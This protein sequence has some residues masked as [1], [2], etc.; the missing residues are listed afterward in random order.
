MKI[1][2]GNSASL[3][4]LK[5]VFWTRIAPRSLA[6]GRGQ[7]DRYALFEKSEEQKR[8]LLIFSRGVL[9][10]DGR[11]GALFFGAYSEVLESKYDHSKRN[12]I[13]APEFLFF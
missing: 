1:I 8:T 6:C 7:A 5:A 9:A 13:E 12:L 4:N 3:E 10:N 2:W 11:C